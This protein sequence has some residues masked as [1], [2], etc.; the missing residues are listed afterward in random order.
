MLIPT[1]L[2]END[3]HRTCHV[4]KDCGVCS[5]KAENS[6]SYCTKYKHC[7]GGKCKRWAQK[8][9]LPTGHC[10]DDKAKIC[11]SRYD[12]PGICSNE[13]NN[14]G[15]SCTKNWQCYEKKLC[16]FQQ[17]IINDVVKVYDSMSNNEKPTLR[18]PE[19]GFYVQHTYY[20]SSPKV[21]TFDTMQEIKNQGL[22]L[23]LRLYYLDTFIDS[24]TLSNTFL[25]HLQ[26]DLRLLRLHGLK[27]I[28][29]F[30]YSDSQYDSPLDAVSYK[31][32]SLSFS[33]QLFI[34][35]HFSLIFDNNQEQSHNSQSHIAN[36]SYINIGTR[37][38]YDNSSWIYW[39]LG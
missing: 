12:C 5:E 8:C 14:A 29:R 33:Y 3:K 27:T 32:D 25:M 17:C 39:R 23:L 10:K 16:I 21:L 30:A 18:N 9:V 38:Y 2:C 4:S 37:C 36:Y 26:N 22:T 28:L 24:P 1:G 6:G 35:Q 13:S 15:S 34:S 11:T 7:D 20:S 19:R 31:Q